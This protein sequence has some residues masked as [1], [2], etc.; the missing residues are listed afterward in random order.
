MV[1]RAVAA[2]L[3]ST[4]LAACATLQPSEDIRR[5]LTGLGLPSPQTAAGIRACIARNP[6][7]RLDVDVTDSSDVAALSNTL[8]TKYH[9]DDFWSTDPFVIA[10]LVTRT[11]AHNVLLGIPPPKL[12]GRVDADVKVFHDHIKAMFAALHNGTNLLNNL[13]EISRDQIGFLPL[14]L[15][16]E[17][18]YFANGFATH[19]GAKL[20]AP[21]QTGGNIP[22]AEIAD[23]ATVFL[24][25]LFDYWDGLDYT[26]DGGGG[27]LLFADSA[28]PANGVELGKLKWWGSGS[29]VAPTATAVI[30]H[31]ASGKAMYNPALRVLAAPENP[32]AGACGLTAREARATTALASWIG[33]RMVIVSGDILEQL[34]SINVGFIIA[35]TSI[36]VGDNKTL[37][38]LAKAGMETIG[39]RAAER[40]LVDFFLNVPAGSVDPLLQLFPPPG[41][42]SP[43]K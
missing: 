8:R 42:T 29:S 7:N 23:A 4:V 40:A 25:A 5:E 26:N 2:L 35:G 31:D 28:W 38:T 30:R 6:H 37:V 27:I 14:L 21:Q 1:V 9:F 17:R 33:R 32:P 20:S 19:F 34:S 18:E 3:L 24:E 41:T 12:F 10:A 39:R 13:N 11:T 36:A 16:Y 43:K 15:V 22:D